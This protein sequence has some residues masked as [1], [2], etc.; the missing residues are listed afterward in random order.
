MILTEGERMLLTTTYHVF[1][2]Y[3]VHQDATRLPVELTTPEYSYGDQ[4]MPALSVSVSRDNEGDTHVSIVN[5]HAHESMQLECQLTGIAATSVS[6]RILTA[7]Q[8]DAH[9]TFDKPEQLQ[10]TSFDGAHLEGASL[11]VDVPPHAV[12]V[13]KL[14]A[15]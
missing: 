15:E 5:A 11:S 3:K 1:E 6:G 13:L 4:S 2:M 10:P 12:I 14:S 9:N 8:L 7:E